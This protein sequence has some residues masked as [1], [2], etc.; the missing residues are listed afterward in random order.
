MDYHVD[1]EVYCTCDNV[2]IDTRFRDLTVCL[3]STDDASGG[4][5]SVFVFFAAGGF[6]SL[7]CD[8]QIATALYGVEPSESLGL[9]WTTPSSYL[10]IDQVDRSVR[11]WS[12]AEDD[13]DQHEYCEMRDVC[14]AVRCPPN[15]IKKSCA[16]IESG[17]EEAGM[18]CPEG[19]WC[20]C[21]PCLD[22]S[23][24]GRQPGRCALECRHAR[25]A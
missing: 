9:A 11:H 17:C 1:G 15:T 19:Y 25:H 23:V 8:A 7:G 21:S 5:W 14:A 20:L 13:A 10:D 22:L 6:L 12:Q 24:R 4:A 16:Q 2:W 18:A 3:Q